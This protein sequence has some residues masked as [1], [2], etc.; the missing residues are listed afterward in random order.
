[1]DTANGSITGTSTPSSVHFSDD[2]ASVVVDDASVANEDV[3][4]STDATQQQTNKHEEYDLTAEEVAALN[5][6]EYIV[7]LKETDTFFLFEQLDES[8]ANDA[9]FLDEVRMNNKKYEQVQNII[10][11]YIFQ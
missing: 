4:A 3:K 11:I 2:D 6:S 1:M 10:F 5:E 9:E 7:Q 8:I